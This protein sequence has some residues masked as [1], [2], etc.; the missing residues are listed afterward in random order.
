M[1]NVI[2]FAL[3]AMVV[4]LIL[5]AYAK[6]QPIQLTDDAAHTITLQQP[7]QR[8]ISLYPAFTDMLVAMGAEGQ[9]VGKTQ[10]DI[11]PGLA[12]VPSVGTHMRPS[13]EIITAL[14]PDV[15]IQLEGR[16]EAALLAGQLERLGITVVRFN[17]GSFTDIFACL[18]RLGIL[19]GHSDQ[20]SALVQTMQKDLADIAA[21][22]AQQATQPTVFFEVRYPNLLGAGGGSMVQDIISRAGGVNVLAQYPEKMV[23]LNEESLV[24]LN[25]TVYVLQQG[26]MNKSP[27][28]PPQRPHFAKLGAV[29]NNHWYVVDEALFSRPGVHSVQAVRVLVQLF[30]PAALVPVAK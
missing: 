24:A 14:Q 5:P 2:Y 30:Y 6:A 19:T 26:G 17:L 1:R 13:V 18:Q 29:V 23:R 21:V 8:I 25:P 11:H 4:T 22:V 9:L 15:V 20:A 10:N 16:D 12:S 3:A 28:L 7:A 27:V